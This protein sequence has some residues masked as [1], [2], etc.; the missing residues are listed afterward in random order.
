MVSITN[1]QNG[2][3]R[4]IRILG[5]GGFGITY[6]AE[7]TMLDKMVAI[8]EFFPK[9]YC[10]RNESTSHVT[11][12]TKNNV[13]L[14]A[15]L[16]RKFLKEAKNIAKLDHPGIVKIHDIFEE[17]NT[18]YYVMDYIDG[19]NLSNIVKSGGPLSENKAIEYIIKVGK[20]LE[21]IHSKKMT[22]FD[23]KPTN[24]IIK[25]ENDEPILIDFGLSKQYSTGSEETS[26][27][28]NAVSNGFSPL[29]LYNPEN[30]KEFSPQSDVYSLGA[31]LYYLLT[32]IVPPK[33]ITLIESQLEI[34][35]Q[36]DFL[37][38]LSKNIS[39]A[40]EQSLV[41]NKDSRFESVSSFI[42]YIIGNSSEIKSDNTIIITSD[43]PGY[44]ELIDERCEINDNLRYYT[45]RIFKNSYKSFEYYKTAANSG[46][47][48]FQ[49]YLGIMY[50]IGQG[51]KIDIYKAYTLYKS[52]ADM[53]Y[54]EA[55]YN[56]GR[57]REFGYNP[58]GSD[59]SALD[60]YRIA[61]NGGH[62]LA[63]IALGCI[64]E[65]GK[66][67][68]IDY[69]EALKWYNKA[70]A[71]ECSLGYI[72][73]ANMYDEG[74]GVDKNKKKVQNLLNNAI[75]TECPLCLTQVALFLYSED[76]YDETFKNVK[77]A[78]DK[79]LPSAMYSLCSLY[80]NEVGIDKDIKTAY[81]WLMK[82]AEHG[83]S[84]A[85]ELLGDIYSKGINEDSFIIKQDS[86]KAIEWYEQAAE[87]MNAES[88]NKIGICYLD[89]YIV[90]KNPET[91]VEWFRK[92][93]ILGNAT[94]QYKIAHCYYTGMGV[95][96]NYKL[97]AEWYHK[98]AEQGNKDAQNRLG[99]FYYSGKGVIKDYT[100]AVE[101]FKKA[102]DQ[103]YEW[104]QKNLANCYYNG[105]GVE[106]NYNL[107]AEWYR[108]AAEQ[109]NTHAQNILGNLYYN[110]KGVVKDYTK[111]AEW[112]RK[113]ADKGYA[114]AQ[115]NLAE[116]YFDGDGIKKNFTKAK[117][118]YENAAKNGNDKAKKKN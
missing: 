10:D 109:G 57:L 92:A 38:A 20:A 24:I 14:V 34:E 59:L 55:F 62:A 27:I 17:N 45:K 90:E 91:A 52:A 71:K 68:K 54:V 77:I 78:A 105:E 26:T 102:A 63:M 61:A 8:K 31:T 79:G 60:L 49:N 47:P 44:N 23:V 112:Y 117:E 53:N 84:R 19:E 73:L 48:E 32:G 118:L 97:A 88:M 106:Q 110:G 6:L 42:E 50:E 16:K 56:L 80:Y 28:I 72:Y 66:L 113:A 98:A 43:T 89:G 36:L 33:A 22:H 69:S 75:K 5:Q 81:D 9:E 114:W 99:N 4:I 11:V 83:Y 1:L 58:D 107:A 108:K 82:S 104:A 25:K 21:Y 115:Y 3:Y 46:I 40:I 35:S 87:L 39:K 95:V 51:T 12:G 116:M 67:I 41:I 100:K 18:A 7:H 65:E 70:I 30:L 74:H 111:A 15:S 85:M 37:D 64:Y 76:K 94:A 86:A 96:Q 103:G 93:A 29:E 13:E 101:W 2:K